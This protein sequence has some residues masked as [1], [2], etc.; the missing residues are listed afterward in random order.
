LGQRG[1]PAC[2]TERRTGPL[3]EHRAC[4]VSVELSA[5]CG[6]A[7][8]SPSPMDHRWDEVLQAEERRRAEAARFGRNAI[9]RDADVERRDLLERART[10]A[11]VNRSPWEIGA[12]HWDQRDLYTRNSSL[13]DAGYGRGPSVHPDI[14]SYA[15]HRDDIV[16]APARTRG[17]SEGPSLYEREAWPWLNYERVQA[18][19]DHEGSGV[20]GRV[21]H[22]ASRVVGVLTGHPHRH[23]GPKGWRRADAAI[24][25]D[26]CEA[27]AYDEVLDAGDI[28]VE[29]KD[30]EVTLTG[31]VR[32]R[33]SKRR[34]ELLA[35]RVRAVHDV[36][37]RLTVR[38]NDDD[39]SFTSP[40]PAF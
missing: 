38:K 18:V 6:M 27:L 28:E 1:K 37:N 15:Y 23:T 32:D 34:A 12:S 26:V 24:R 16:P 25:E 9:A 13:D 22:E 2:L 19:P 30:S 21:K 5:A 39:L 20:W 36:H 29:V 3:D 35:D 10:R 8:A 40:V 14:G 31:T 17:G 11:R 4:V 7:F 33:P